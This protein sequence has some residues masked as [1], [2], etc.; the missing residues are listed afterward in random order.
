MIK[1]IVGAV[2]AVSIILSLFSCSGKK[3]D[4]E[5]SKKESKLQ[6]RVAD[7]P[8][9]YKEFF[10]YTFDGN[11]TIDTRYDG[12]AYEGTEKE[13]DYRSYSL[14]YGCKDGTE[15]CGSLT[16]GEFTNEDRKLY[17][18]EQRMTN[19]QVNWF[20][21]TEMQKIAEKEFIE[22]ILNKY[23]DVEY[24]AYGLFCETEE[25]DEFSCIVQASYPI[26][27]VMIGNNLYEKSCRVI[28]SNVA[29]ETGLKLSEADLKTSANDRGFHLDVCI[30]VKNDNDIQPYIEKMENIIS[31]YFA[32]T[33]FPMNC[34]FL[35]NKA[36]DGPRGDTETIYNRSFLMG[37]EL[38]EDEE[39]KYDTCNIWT[40]NGLDDEIMRICLEE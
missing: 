18:S 29:P 12:V 34:T 17:G 2:S 23:L 19:E 16:I 5:R 27:K 20:C 1:R 26:D 13:Y 32:Y 10:D 6:N 7:F 37:R 4:T 9:I 3:S 24:I 15:R 31:D 35:I 14:T 28:E 8:E 25:N 40:T 39:E 11:Y 36:P 21:H 22:N 33:G 30:Y 38:S